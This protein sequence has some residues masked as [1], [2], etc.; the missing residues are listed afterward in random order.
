MIEIKFFF[1]GMYNIII[2][3]DNYVIWNLKKEGYIEWKNDSKI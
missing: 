1:N 3:Y 2:K